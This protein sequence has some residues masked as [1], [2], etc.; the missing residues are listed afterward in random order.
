M[1]DLRLHHPH[2]QR[3]HPHPQRH[4]FETIF[5]SIR[6]TPRFC[7]KPPKSIA[8]SG[9]SLCTTN[10]GLPPVFLFNSFQR[11]HQASESRKHQSKTKAVSAV[12]VLQRSFFWLSR[13]WEITT[14]P[15]FASDLP[16]SPPN[17]LELSPTS[18]PRTNNLSP[19]PI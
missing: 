6:E 7:A 12:W 10:E 4:Q 17:L 15:F 19:H 9:T 18:T 16:L 13:S 11:I 2:P 8:I 5:S 1:V 14:F 3:H